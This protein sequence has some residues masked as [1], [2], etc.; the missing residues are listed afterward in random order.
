MVLNQ[1]GRKEEKALN[2]S[3]WCVLASKGGGKKGELV[4]RRGDGWSWVKS[5]EVFIRG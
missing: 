5:S 3:E 4:G 1:Q 2:E